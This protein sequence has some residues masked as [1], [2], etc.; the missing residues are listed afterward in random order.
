MNREWAS[1]LRYIIVAAV[2]AV[3]GAYGACLI[4]DAVVAHFGG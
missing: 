2:L 4:L 3:A 1:V